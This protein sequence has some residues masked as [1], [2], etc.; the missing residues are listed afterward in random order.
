[1][2]E[3]KT[4]KKNKKNKKKINIKV[5]IRQL[6]LSVLYLLIFAGIGIF[7][8]YNS[9]YGN[10]DKTVE[11]AYGCFEGSNW[12]KLYDISVVEESKLV[13][14]TTFTNA[15]NNQLEEVDVNTIEQAGVKE[16]EDVTIIDI[17]YVKG[18]EKEKTSIKLIK[19]DEKKY[20]FFP[21]WKV[22]L[23]ELI[24]T[25]VTIKVPYG[26]TATIDGIDISEI[27]RLY[28]PEENMMKY[29]I[30]R[31]FAGTHALSLK[32]EGMQDINEYIDLSV[33]GTD[34]VV[35][36]DKVILE[37]YIATNAPE[38]VFELYRCGLESQGAATLFDY[39]TDNGCKQLQ[40][41]Y[42]E[43]YNDINAENGAYLRVIENVEYDVSVANSVE[44]ESV[45]AIVHFTCTY[46]A[47]TPRNMNSGVRKDYEGSAE[48][49]VTIHYVVSGD[50]YIADSMDF[51]C[52]DYAME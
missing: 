35:S 12:G 17:S 3:K 7:L 22:D 29:Y 23:S 2:E 48:S 21:V 26:Y 50:E 45:D 9:I 24:A 42:D 19:S 49:T 18:E 52:I 30:D 25:N 46:W 51:K 4:E 1:M 28:F 13:N 10:P 16:D 39:F 8:A 36:G 27:E 33:S 11:L 38:I 31:I 32:R 15:M 37:E 20:M 14:L 41:I 47:K 40:T 5:L 43:L 44:G 34:Y 6:A